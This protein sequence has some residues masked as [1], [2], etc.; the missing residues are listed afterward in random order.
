MFVAP[1]YLQ[2]LPSCALIFQGC[3]CPRAELINPSGS[4]GEGWR[5]LWTSCFGGSI[6]LPSPFSYLKVFGKT[7]TG[8]I[9][10]LSLADPSVDVILEKVRAWQV[11]GEDKGLMQPFPGLCNFL[12][13]VSKNE[14]LNFNLFF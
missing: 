5:A 11:S 6:L 3:G 8:D 7:K 10:A 14:I 4:E 13:S 12:N 1:Y 9:P 2:L